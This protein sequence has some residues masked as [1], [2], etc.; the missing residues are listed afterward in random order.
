MCTVSP[1]EQSEGLFIYLSNQN[2]MTPTIKAFSIEYTLK[3][4]DYNYIAQHNHN[5][6]IVFRGWYDG[7]MMKTCTTLV[8]IW[9]LKATKQ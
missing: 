6:H 3:H 1:T 8:A 9:H 4:I 2:N 5:D 7:A